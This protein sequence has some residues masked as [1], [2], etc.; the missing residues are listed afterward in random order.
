MA[1]ISGNRQNLPLALFLIGAFL[2][3]YSWYQRS[4]IPQPTEAEIS[5]YVEAQYMIEH[6]RMQQGS[7]RPFTMTPEWE[8]K[9]KTALRAQATRPYD[10]RRDQTERM[11]G[12]GL[13]ILVLGTGGLVG[14]LS[15]SRK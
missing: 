6:E 5:N 3:G 11:M 4:Q 1:L 8:A 7:D 15:N 10:E 13:V 12:I 14:R 2:A 9:H